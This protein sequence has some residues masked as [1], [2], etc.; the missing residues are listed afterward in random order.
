MNEVAHND[1][2]KPEAQT[3]SLK[4]YHSLVPATSKQNHLNL[5]Q[6]VW[7]P[8]MYVAGSVLG[9]RN[10]VRTNKNMGYPHGD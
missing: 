9:T 1:T 7:I 4:G 10:S 2:M 3:C 6:Y 5:Q 8:T